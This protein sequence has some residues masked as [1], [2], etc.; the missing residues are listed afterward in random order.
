MIICAD[1]RTFVPGDAVLRCFALDEP[2]KSAHGNGMV[3]AQVVLSLHALQVDFSTVTVGVEVA[4]AAVVVVGEEVIA[5]IFVVNGV[6]S[7]PC[8]W[9]RSALRERTHKTLCI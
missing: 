8:R 6:R 7:L 9:R 5:V 2:C 4:G 1:L 3:T